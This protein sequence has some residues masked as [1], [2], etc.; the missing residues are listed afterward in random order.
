MR[1]GH[2]RGTWTKVEQTERAAVDV[3]AA[4]M[5][6]QEAEQQQRRGRLR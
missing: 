2:V 6:R 1:Q 4:V 3:I 5:A